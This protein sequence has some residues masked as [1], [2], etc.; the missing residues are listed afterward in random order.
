MHDALAAHP[1]RTRDPS[2]AR[3]FYVPIWLA[4]SRHVRLCGNSSQT[5]LRRMVAAAAALSQAQAF[6]HP[7]ARGFPSGWN[8]AYAHTANG[9]PHVSARLGALSKLLWG[10]SV[11]GLERAYNPIGIH[12]L[13]ANSRCTVE[14]PLVANMH[15][16]PALAARA[17]SALRS[18]LLY[19]S[20]SIHVCC[21]DHNRGPSIRRAIGRLANLTSFSANRTHLLQ[22][23]LGTLNL[24][25]HHA[26]R[27]GACLRCSPATNPRCAPALLAA[28]GHA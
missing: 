13:T 10:A 20:G 1:S 26:I 17:P 25:P 7:S 11:S 15:S 22:A 3:L 5:H 18:I 12:R 23:S 24:T 2:K 6:R 8:H 27:T 21:E 14:I 28:T 4:T 9:F 19:F 16:A